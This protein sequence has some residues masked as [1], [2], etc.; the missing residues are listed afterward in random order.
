MTSDMNITWQNSALCS[1]YD[2]GLDISNA[3]YILVYWYII[4]G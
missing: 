1:E 2:A 4:E 3:M